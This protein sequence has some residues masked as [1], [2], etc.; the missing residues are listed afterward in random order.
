MQMRRMNINRHV[1]VDTHAAC[2]HDTVTLVNP[3]NVLRN[4][5]YIS[6]SDAAVHA[7]DKLGR[8]AYKHMHYLFQ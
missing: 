4:L 2:C 7:V 1:R 5:A 3:S 8:D 6:A